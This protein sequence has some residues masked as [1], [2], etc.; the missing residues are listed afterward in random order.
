MKSPATLAALLENFFTQRLMSQRQASPHTISSYRDTFRLLLTF[1]QG[2]LH[3]PPSRLDLTEIDAPLIAA[4]L[5][6]LENSRGITARSRNLRL[7]AIRSFFHYAAYEEPSR[8]SQIQ[9]V[10][11]IPSKRHTRALVHFLNRSEVDA[12]LAA[13]DQRTWFGRRDHALLL[14]AVQTGLRLS[15]LTGL[16]RPDVSLGTGAYV[17]CVGKGRKERCT[18][19][20]KMT[21]AVLKAWLQEPTRHNA[22][23]LFPSASGGRL[24]PDSVSDL[25]AKH[26]AHAGHTCPSLRQKHVTPHVLRHTLAMELLQEGVDRAVIA[27][28]LGHE[29]VETTQIYLDANLTLKEEIL[30]KTTSPDGKPGRY[31]ADD[32]L[33]AF[34]KRL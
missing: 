26:V 16:Q 13:P 4:F 33:L 28:W 31:R 29:S 1:A 9:R 24:S 12:L 10:L 27:L 5:D 6:D 17:R 7:T 19:L 32:E 14:V 20:T 18:P 25:L 34:L 22:Q 11:A 3:K 30:A 23:A 21:A 2:R 15:E 8:A